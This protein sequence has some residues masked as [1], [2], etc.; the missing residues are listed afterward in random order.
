[1]AAKVTFANLN[2]RTQPAPFLSLHTERLRTEPEPVAMATTT[3][4]GVEGVKRRHTSLSEGHQKES[5]VD[6]ALPTDMPEREET[7]EM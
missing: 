4:S 1:M 3:P 5:S 2:G 6:S 7:N